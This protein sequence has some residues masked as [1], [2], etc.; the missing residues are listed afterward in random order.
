M[1]DLIRRHN[2]LNGIPFTITEFALIALVMGVFGT[3]HLVRHNFTFAVIEWGIAVNG[4]LFVMIGVRMLM[5]RDEA[6]KRTAS[7][8]NKQARQ[9]HL[10]ENPHM[11]RDTLTLTAATLI[12]FVTLTLVLYQLIARR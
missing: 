12:P 7:F 11:L 5:D 8:W 9:Q 6:E 10:R 3:L 1:T 4:L 2:R